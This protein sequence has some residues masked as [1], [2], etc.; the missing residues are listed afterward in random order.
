MTPIMEPLH[1]LVEKYKIPAADLELHDFDFNLLSLIPRPL[2]ERHQILP[3]S[4]TGSRLTVAMPNPTDLHSLHA[5]QFKTGLSIFPVAVTENTFRDAMRRFYLMGDSENDA[6][7][8][9]VETPEEQEEVDP[10]VA[11]K[12]AEDF[13]KA[14]IA[15]DEDAPAV[16]VIDPNPEEESNDDAKTLRERLLISPGG[17]YDV[18]L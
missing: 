1:E 12:I 8:D 15:P 2:A 13:L 9:S 5:A 6:E 14:L 16:E 4:R 11:A 10:N 7:A 18:R 17:S 3:L